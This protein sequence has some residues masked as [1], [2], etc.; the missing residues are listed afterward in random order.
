M[1]GEDAQDECGRLIGAASSSSS[2][3]RLV[4]WLREQGM[5]LAYGG[6]GSKVLYHL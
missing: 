2:M 4:A 6:G 5:P 3:L 1:D